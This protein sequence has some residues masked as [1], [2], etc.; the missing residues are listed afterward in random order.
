MLRLT[1]SGQTTDG[2][3]EKT[4]ANS[5]LVPNKEGEVDTFSEVIETIRKRKHK[6]RVKSGNRW[7]AIGLTFRLDV[8]SSVMILFDELFSILQHIQHPT[9]VRLQF[10][11]ECLEGKMREGR[12]HMVLGGTPDRQTDRQTDSLTER[13]TEPRE[14]DKKIY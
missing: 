12:Q 10:R 2:W 14:P 6:C 5:F 8:V 3:T 7:G 13:L 1:D 4:N 11:L 9:F